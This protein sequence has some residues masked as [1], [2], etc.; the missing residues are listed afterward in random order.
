MSTKL[1][2]LLAKYRQ[3]Q[4]TPE[5]IAYIKERLAEFQEL[6]DLALE[7]EHAEWEK[8]DLSVEDQQFKQK[9]NRQIKKNWFKTLLMTI[10]IL[11]VLTGIGYFALPKI[12]DQFYY[13][14][15]G[16]D[17]DKVAPFSLSFMVAYELQNPFISINDIKINAL[18]YGNYDVETILGKRGETSFDYPLP[19]KM[20][21]RKGEVVN[22]NYAIRT[23]SAL[24][25][26][27][28]KASETFEYQ[29]FENL[30]ESMLKQLA[31][32]P[33]YSQIYASLTFK[34]S[35]TLEQVQKIEEEEYTHIYWYGVQPPNDKT[36]LL[37]FRDIGTVPYT[38]TAEDKDKKYLEKLNQKYPYLFMGI[39]TSNQYP[40]NFQYDRFQSLLQF[41]LDNQEHFQNLFHYEYLNKEIKAYQKELQNKDNFKISSVYTVTTVAS[42]QNILKKYPDC[43][44]KIEKIELYNQNM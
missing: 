30:R 20:E 27:S 37:G 24:L 1:L 9:I 14:P 13:N 8:P 42:L 38:L 29:T 10:S 32:L 23:S 18:G 16:K 40:E 25:R 5:E 21:I 33:P 6:Q 17:G 4:A 19:T 12:V 34:P 15:I 2:E 28:T 39:Q 26:F 36:G 35:V 43:F 7:E 44:A 11:L 41:M 22:N 31:T 3:N